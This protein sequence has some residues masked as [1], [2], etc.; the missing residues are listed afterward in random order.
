MIQPFTCIG[1]LKSRERGTL[2]NMGKIRQRKERDGSAFHF[3]CQ[4]YSLTS[5]APTAIRL[6]ETFTFYCLQFF[7]FQNLGLM[8]TFLGTTVFTINTVVLKVT[9]HERFSFF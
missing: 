1:L 4:K 7:F 2:S 9:Q 3:L 5:T 8:E 6:W